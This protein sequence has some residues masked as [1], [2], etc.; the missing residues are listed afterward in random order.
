MNQYPGKYN[1][2]PFFTG[3]RMNTEPV[4]TFRE[5]FRGTQETRNAEAPG[6][7]LAENQPIQDLPASEVS[8]VSDKS[9]PDTVEFI[10]LPVDVSNSIVP[11]SRPHS[12]PR[13]EPAVEWDTMSL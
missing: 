3:T 7:N 2:F 6:Q 8:P 13:Y 1:T 10:L 12:C 9:S 11:P 4:M 5:S